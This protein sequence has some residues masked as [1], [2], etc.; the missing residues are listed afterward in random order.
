MTKQEWIELLQDS[1]NGGDTPDE[2]VRRFHP[3]II[4]KNISIAFTAFLTQP[5]M[6]DNMRS[7]ASW[8][9]DALTKPYKIKIEKDSTTERQFIPLPPGIVFM[10]NNSQ[11][12]EIV[13]VKDKSLVYVHRS[14]S[15]SRIFGD[16]QIKDVSNAVPY[17]LVGN[18]MYFDPICEFKEGEEMVVY[19][20]MDFSSFEREEE[21]NIPGEYEVMVLKGVRELLSG[22]PVED[23]INDNNNLQQ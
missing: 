22:R 5:D 15:S 13:N 7:I 4:E 20:V 19:L 6:N 9:L 21:V 14:I 18:K 16:L 11:I 2:R 12:R 8:K 17:M 23:N 10:K 1:L 3:V